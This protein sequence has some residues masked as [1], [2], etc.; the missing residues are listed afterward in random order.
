MDISNAH[1]LAQALPEDATR[2][3]GIRVTLPASDPVQRLL[4]A[5]WRKE[6]WF[7]SR[8]ERDAALQDM[9]SRHAYSRRGDLPTP[10]LAAI[11]R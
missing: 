6:H 11:E 4:D 10:L 8:E 3:F 5:N 9:A 1:N 2:R 7:A